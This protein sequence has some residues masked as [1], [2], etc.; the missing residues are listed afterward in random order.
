MVMSSVF[1]DVHPHRTSV[2]A[3]GETGVLFLAGVYC[4]VGPRAKHSGEKCRTQCLRCFYMSVPR[5]YGIREDSPE[6]GVCAD[7]YYRDIER[8]ELDAAENDPKG[9]M[10]YSD[11]KAET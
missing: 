6:D 5:S 9:K 10:V 4:V 2:A 3:T 1:R 7:C 11:D 8:E